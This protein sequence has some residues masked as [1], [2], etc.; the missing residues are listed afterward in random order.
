MTLSG[1][2]TIWD[3]GLQKR[4]DTIGKRGEFTYIIEI[5]PKLNFAAIGQ[6][7]I[8]EF[9]YQ[10]HLKKKNLNEKIKKG[11]CCEDINDRVLLSFC[12]QKDITVFELTKNGIKEHPPN[13]V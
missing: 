7:F 8:Y 6:V 13:A 1:E 11:I 3:N 2:L 5:K 10:N 4:I 12:S 9:L